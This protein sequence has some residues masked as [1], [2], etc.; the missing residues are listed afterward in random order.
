MIT[1]ENSHVL[2]IKSL[3]VNDQGRYEFTAGG[4]STQCMLRING[5]NLMSSK[6]TASRILAWILINCRVS[7]THD[8]EPNV[9]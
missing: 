4:K 7:T 6:L 1:R 9:S 8:F 5:E 2:I 3:G